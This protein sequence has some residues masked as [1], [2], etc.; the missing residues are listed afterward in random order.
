MQDLMMFNIPFPLMETAVSAIMAF[1]LGLFWYHPKVMGTRWMEARG[2]TVSDLN[3]RA[4][5]F[6]YNLS[7]WFIAAAFYGFLVLLLDVN[8]APALISLACLLWVAFAMPPTVMG[9]LYTG[10]SFEAVAIDTAYQ[11]GGYYL[12]AMVHIVFMLF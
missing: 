5:T 12:F 1:I 3:P 4:K 6:F 7:L 2:K 8:S 10:Y 11:L 9:A